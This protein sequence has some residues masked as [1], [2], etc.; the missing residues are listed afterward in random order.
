MAQ[1]TPPFRNYLVIDSP[2]L[3]GAGRAAGVS[4]WQRL[5][6]IFLFIAIV[7][8]GFIAIKPAPALSVSN[9][10]AEVAT[11]AAVAETIGIAPAAPV[12]VQ[13]LAKMSHYWP[14]LGGV[15]CAQFVGGK[16]VSRMA[17]GL[18]WEEWVGRAA[19]CPAELPFG[20]EV[21]LPGGETF[22]CLDRGGKVVTTAA[23]ELWIDLLV[24]RA[25]VPYGTVM[26]VTVRLP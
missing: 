14:P 10:A 17:S 23:G 24:E 5:G 22:T 3:P 7:V 12:G 1:Y 21:E 9:T 16:C 18:P 20:T 25:P 15:N 19:A 2:L 26:P 4:S 6:I 8:P 11:G 13:R